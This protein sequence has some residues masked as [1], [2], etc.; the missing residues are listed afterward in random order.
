[1]T[2]KHSAVSRDYS[3]ALIRYSGPLMLSVR[4]LLKKPSRKARGLRSGHPSPTVA[5]VK[6]RFNMARKLIVVRGVRYGVMVDVHT[7]DARS[8]IEKRIDEGRDLPKW[9]VVLADDEWP[10]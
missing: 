6:G 1:M 8:A 10:F 4:R 5:T 2:R 3:D 9:A 7:K